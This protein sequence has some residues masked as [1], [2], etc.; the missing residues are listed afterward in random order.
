MYGWNRHGW[1]MMQPSL[2]IFDLWDKIVY[3]RRGDQEKPLKVLILPILFP[4]KILNKKQMYILR[5]MTEINATF[6]D[7]KELVEIPLSS[8]H[9]IPTGTPVEISQMS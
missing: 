1:E 4:A 9:N 7:V 6:K 2:W 5:E 3:Q 8:P